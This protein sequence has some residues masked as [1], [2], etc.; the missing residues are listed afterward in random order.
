MFRLFA[1]AISSASLDRKFLLAVCTNRAERR[2]LVPDSA[3]EAEVG[4]RGSGLA[5]LAAADAAAGSMPLGSIS[6]ICWDALTG[7]GFTGRR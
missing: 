4:A 1:C 2:T 3:A 5:L 7:V 6:S